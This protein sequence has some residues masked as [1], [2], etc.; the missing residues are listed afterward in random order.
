[1]SPSLWIALFSCVA[2]ATLASAITAH[3]VGARATRLVAWILAAS[4]WWS[5]CQVLSLVQPDPQSFAPRAVMYIGPSLM[6][7]YTIQADVYATAGPRGRRK[8]E[9][10]IINSGYTFLAAGI[11]QRLEIR[12]WGSELR[13]MQRQ[14]FAWDVDT[15]YTMK[16]RVD[17]ESDGKGGERA[18]VRGKMWKRQDPEPADWTFTVHDPLPIKSGAP[19]LYGFTPVEGYFDNVLITESQ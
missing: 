2:A 17:L 14:D 4:A 19:G 8:P 10:G 11:Q 5:L 7:G 16:L 9:L 13:M 12:S 3:G 6:S 18:A 15:W 1:M